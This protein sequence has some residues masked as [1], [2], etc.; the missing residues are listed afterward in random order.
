MDQ[1]HFRYSS[2]QSSHL[3]LTVIPFK[4]VINIFTWRLLSVIP[5]RSIRNRHGI[6][7]RFI[8][9]TQIV[10]VPY[11]ATSIDITR[12]SGIGD[13]DR[14]TVLQIFS[15]HAIVMHDVA[16]TVQNSLGSSGP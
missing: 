7:E 12:R 5:S 3:G 11:P 6:R 4:L 14:A 9:T 1:H 16:P 15:M 13:T 2:R 10:D 8:H